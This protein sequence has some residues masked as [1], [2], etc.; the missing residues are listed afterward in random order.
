MQDIQLSLFSEIKEDLIKKQKTAKLGRYERIKRELEA[1]DDDSYKIFVE[2]KSSPPLIPYKFVDL[3]CGAGGMTQ[4]LV[5]AGLKPIASVEV[6]PIASATYT[7]N[8]QN[9]HHFC[10]DIET[11]SPKN[12]LKDLCSA[13]AHLVV[14]DQPC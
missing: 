10:G 14:G 4:G 11:F 2:V 13:E 6:N 1:N 8:F 9:C 7:R 12:W 5:E 3:F